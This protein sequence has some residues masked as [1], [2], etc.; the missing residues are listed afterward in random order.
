MPLIVWTSAS[1][2]GLPR[3][4]RISRATTLSISD[5]APA[6]DG[7]SALSTV[8]DDAYAAPSSRG[9]DDRRLW[10]GAPPLDL[11]PPAVAEAPAPRSRAPP[12]EPPAR[13]AQAVE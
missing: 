7:G 6:Y 8:D 9:K 2:V 11:P 1:T 5:M 13:R 12:G 3:E 4:S 10:R